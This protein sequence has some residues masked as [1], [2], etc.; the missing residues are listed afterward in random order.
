VDAPCENLGEKVISPSGLS[1]HFLVGKWV[2]QPLPSQTIPSGNWAFHLWC[3]I[4][5][6]SVVSI[7]AKI[8]KQHDSTQTL[9]ATTN[10]AVIPFL[11]YGETDVTATFP[12]TQMAQG[13]KITVE[14][15]LYSPPEGRV[16]ARPTVR[17]A[18]D[19]T[20]RNS[21]INTTPI[22]L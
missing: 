21:R 7:Y 10:Q 14:V 18:Y 12:E 16:G 4:N 6:R 5:T 13:D 8:Y 17:F 2:T 15:W 20:N 9:L 19:T 3:Y 11:A 22:Q 1:D